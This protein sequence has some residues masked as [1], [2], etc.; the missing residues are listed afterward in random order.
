[1]AEDGFVS[2]LRVIANSSQTLEQITILCKERSVQKI[3]LGRS[4]NKLFLLP[5]VL[6]EFWK[7]AA[8]ACRI[9]G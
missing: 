2:P 8:I 3:I 4:D 9:S 1:M 5:K 7:S 6:Q